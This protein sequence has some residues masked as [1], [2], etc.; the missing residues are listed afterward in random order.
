[1]LELESRE[2]SFWDLRARSSPRGLRYYGDLVHTE[3]RKL[4]SLHRHALSLLGDIRGKR[5][6]DCGCGYGAIS[7]HLAKRG[8]RVTAM[9]I[10]AESVAI[11]REWF[12]L[13]GVSQNVET[14]I[15]S[16]RRLPFADASFDFIV[17]SCILHHLDLEH[18]APELRRVLKP[19][20]RGV[21]VENNGASRALM[22]FRNKVL[23]PLNLRRGSQD[24]APLDTARLAVIR[25]SFP[26]LRRHFPEMVFFRLAASFF[27]NDFGPLRRALEGLD[28]LVVRVLP[29]A[30]TSSYFSIVEMGTGPWNGAQ[31]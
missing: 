25:R 15:G 4:L 18:A 13:N 2:Q 21:F 24:E 22:F 11:A 9:D 29:G 23:A 3:D 28:A 17:G 14:H 16:V 5:I 6:L 7:C 12:E 26:S 27:F 31:S 1:M 8:A 20:G 19:G 10:S 30:R